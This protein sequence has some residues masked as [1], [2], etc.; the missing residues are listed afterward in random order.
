[1]TNSPDNASQGASPEENKPSA[2]IIDF[3]GTTVGEIPPDSVLQGALSQLDEVVIVGS[4]KE[5]GEIYLGSSSGSN[6]DI[7]WLLAQGMF[8][9]MLES[10]KDE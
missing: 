6:P 9:L 2:E 3:P 4:L 10:R 1:M 5:T 7:L 8:E